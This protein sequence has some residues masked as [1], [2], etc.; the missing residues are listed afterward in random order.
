LFLET[1]ARACRILNFSEHSLKRGGSD[2][3]Q[4]QGIC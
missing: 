3:G 2:H 4:D 1:S